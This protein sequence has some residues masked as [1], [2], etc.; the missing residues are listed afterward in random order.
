MKHNFKE[1]TIWKRVRRLIQDIYS[2]TDDYPPSVKYDLVA[3]IRRASLSASLNIIEGTGRSTP[4]QLA[5]FLDIAYGSLKEIKGCLIHSFDLG[6]IKENDLKHYENETIELQKMIYA[7]RLKILS[8]S[9]DKQ[10]SNYS[11]TIKS[12]NLTI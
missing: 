10:P 8:E 4:K 1:L 9:N 6:Y 11:E 2:L 7:F 5:H 12:R 3:Q